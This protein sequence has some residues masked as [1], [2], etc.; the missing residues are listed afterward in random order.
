MKKQ[1]DNYSYN[2]SFLRKHTELRH[3]RRV[4]IEGSLKEGYKSF[5]VTV[6][7]E[8]GVLYNK[9]V[10]YYL[11]NNG[12]TKTD[13]F[14]KA[15]FKYEKEVFEK[16]FTIEKQARILVRG[17]NTP[18]LWSDGIESKSRKDLNENEVNISVRFSFEA[19][20]VLNKMY[21]CYNPSFDKKTK[22]I[23]LIEII[24][25]YAFEDFVKNKTLMNQQKEKIKVEKL[26][27]E[28][29]HQQK[30][31][32][33]ELKQKEEEYEL[34]LKQQ[35]DE[36]EQRLKHKDEENVQLRKVIKTQQTTLSFSSS[37]I[38]PVDMVYVDSNPDKILRIPPQAQFP[39]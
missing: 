38:Q 3:G 11:E 15:V 31:H 25:N 34:K 1:D 27:Q 36:Y 14:S 2:V 16:E 30:E 28:L 9:T 19:I 37:N 26:K 23:P 5:R 24:T 21:G 32:E 29:K 35:R 6:S 22:I 12:L 7:K 8:I 20:S 18:L 10:P 4:V 33:Q 39:N 13:F 17:V